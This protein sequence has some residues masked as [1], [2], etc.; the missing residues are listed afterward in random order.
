MSLPVADVIV[1]DGFVGN[2]LL[3]FAVGEIVLQIPREEL[4]QGL[5]GQL[6]QVC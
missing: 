4:P 1:C 3:K 2:V 5:H 6:G